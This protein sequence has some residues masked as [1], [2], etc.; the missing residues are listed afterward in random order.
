MVCSKG[1]CSSRRN[2]SLQVPTVELPGDSAR[3]MDEMSKETRM[4]LV[5]LVD[6][7]QRME[8]CPIFRAQLFSLSYF[9]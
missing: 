6:N 7:S 3:N 1:G 2:I 4:K 9:E 5:I 8:L